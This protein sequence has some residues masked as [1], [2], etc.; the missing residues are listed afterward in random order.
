MLFS[1]V[2]IDCFSLYLMADGG[3][4]ANINVFRLHHDVDNDDVNGDYDDSDGIAKCIDFVLKN[5]LLFYLLYFCFICC[6]NTIFPDIMTS[7][8]MF[9]FVR[10]SYSEYYILIIKEFVIIFYQFVVVV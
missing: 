7:C 5:V 9:S 1:I 2:V 4:M 10:K 3:W 8:L 6:Y